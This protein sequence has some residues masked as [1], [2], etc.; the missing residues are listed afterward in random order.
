MIAQRYREAVPRSAAHV[1]VWAQRVKLGVGQEKS[2]AQ[3]RS[4]RTSVARKDQPWKNRTLHTRN[5]ENA[6][7][8]MPHNSLIDRG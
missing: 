8:G 1:A 4:R 2:A 6:S 7:L 5:R 3:L